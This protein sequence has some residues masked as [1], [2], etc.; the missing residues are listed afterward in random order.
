MTIEQNY[1]A[2]FGLPQGFQVDAAL[3]SERYRALQK[4]LHPD[5][6]VQQSEREQ[7]LAVQASA[8]LNEALATLKSPLKRAAYLLTLKGVDTDARSITIS[9]HAFLLQQMTLREQLE[10]ARLA[11]VPLDA[12]EQLLD[13]AESFQRELSASLEQYLA[14]DAAEA[15]D[16]ALQTLRK[17][18]FFDKLRYEIELLEDQLADL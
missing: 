6:H 14:S 5:R 1:F 11:E 15:L 12:L 16:M 17:L 2:L 18:Q 7:L 3:L 4:T 8:H 13:R 10:E 9:D